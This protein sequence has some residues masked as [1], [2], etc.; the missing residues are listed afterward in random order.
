MT[1]PTNT[2]YC[3]RLSVYTGSISDSDEFELTKRERLIPERLNKA[4]DGQQA[5][6][7][8]INKTIRQGSPDTEDDWD[9]DR[10]DLIAMIN[11]DTNALEFF[12]FI[13]RIEEKQT[14]SSAYP[15][16]TGRVIAAF[17]IKNY[18]DNIYITRS[19]QYSGGD[20]VTSVFNGPIPPLNLK[21]NDDTLI[22]NRREVG[23]YDYIATD[24]ADLGGDPD[25]L[26]E[27]ELWYRLKALNYILQIQDD[28]DNSAFRPFQSYLKFRKVTNNDFTGD[29]TDFLLT[30]NGDDSWDISNLTVKEAI[31]LII[32]QNS[33]II[34]T[35]TSNSNPTVSGDTLTILNNF[36][37]NLK[38][39]DSLDSDDYETY[40]TT[41]RLIDYTATKLKS[42]DR[43]ELIGGEIKATGTFTYRAKDSDYR[44]LDEDWPSESTTDGPLGR[45]WSSEDY[46]EDD[47]DFLDGEADH[48]DLVRKNQL[49]NNVFTRFKIWNAN[50]LKTES[51]YNEQGDI[52]DYSRYQIYVL[53][54]EWSRDDDEDDQTFTVDALNKQITF[55]D[56][57]TT[58]SVGSLLTDLNP[59]ICSPL[60]NLTWY[61]G[62]KANGDSRYDT[63]SNTDLAIPV[64]M[65]PVVLLY[66]KYNENLD[67][68][69]YNILKP[70]QDFRKTDIE[71]ERHYP[72]FRLKI[73]T[74]R[75]ALAYNEWSNE[76]ADPAATNLDPRDDN[77]CYAWQDL[78]VTLAIPTG[79]MLQI[80]EDREEGAVVNKVM[81]IERSDWQLWAVHPYTILGLETN[82]SDEFIPDQ[83]GSQWIYTRNDYP[84][85]Y[86]MMKQIKEAAFREGAEMDMEFAGYNDIA[87]LDIGNRI[88]TINVKKGDTTVNSISSYSYVNTITKNFQ[89][90][91]QTITTKTVDVQASVRWAMNLNAPTSVSIQR[92]M[93]GGIASSLGALAPK[94]SPIITVVGEGAGTGSCGIEAIA[95]QI[96]D[97]NDITPS[98][99]TANTIYGI[100]TI[101][102]PVTTVPTA[103]VPDSP[104]PGD[105]D[106]GLS[107]GTLNSGNKVW[108]ANY[109]TGTDENDYEGV[110]VSLPEDSNTWSA[111]QVTVNVSG[112][113]TTRVYVISGY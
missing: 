88:G 30:E 101:G 75:H 17:D 29:I 102:S 56:G 49:Y 68:T 26:I 91:T 58:P 15:G 86:E 69:W 55:A 37:L 28:D 38:R 16:S 66:N 78:F 23:D 35:I 33:N 67:N 22:G 63:R 61:D 112:G 106:D 52:I 3:D 34:W 107:W 48:N 10:Y 98:G 51:D 20:S 84:N 82:D 6:F 4:I 70:S 113:G 108:V 1:T 39:V 100:K 25:N 27:A 73:D 47:P 104:T 85:M 77:G 83:T 13:S 46:I 11:D 81:R 12:G 95:V 36:K 96:G 21:G 99:Y 59:S 92:L 18:L 110:N 31:D 19:I 71:F 62:V 43:I 45:S 80:I 60:Q 44:S 8:L 94:R 2:K 76:D 105:Y 14:L 53:N 7:L 111:T 5:S 41:Q 74:F 57:S 32:G 9:P 24:L 97:G 79:Q 40:N 93:Q 90:G 72:G 50:N 109:V 65:K 42:Y 87:D 64:L 89:T 54:Q 103:E